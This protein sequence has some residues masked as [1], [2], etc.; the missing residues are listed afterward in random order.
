MRGR[1]SRTK[2][3]LKKP[4]SYKTEEATGSNLRDLSEISRGGG[5]V[6]I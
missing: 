4:R 3:K 1:A 5:G 6:G 2:V